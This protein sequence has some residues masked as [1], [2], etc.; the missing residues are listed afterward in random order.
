MSFPR[1]A[2][3][4]KRWDVEIERWTNH[5]LRAEVEKHQLLESLKELLKQL[6]FFGECHYCDRP[7]LEKHPE[8]CPV[9]P[10]IAV[11]E[12]AGKE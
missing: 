7:Y 11:L 3:Q 1:A 6:D 12:A 5:V 4:G 2:G 10:I 9:A 8:E